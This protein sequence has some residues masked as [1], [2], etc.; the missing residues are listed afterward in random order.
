MTPLFS[1]LMG[2]A[3]EEEKIVRLA[4]N[5]KSKVLEIV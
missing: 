5:C 4:S 3:H 2:S 1:M